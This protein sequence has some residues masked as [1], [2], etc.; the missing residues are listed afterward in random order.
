MPEMQEPVLEQAQKRKIYNAEWR[1][2]HLKK[3]AEYRKRWEI[4]N[5][6]K[7]HAAKRRY[8]ARYPEKRK[9]AKEKYT[10]THSPK[11]IS[12]Y[13][14]E[15][16]QKNIDKLRIKGREYYTKHCEQVKLYARRKRM[17]LKLEV[18]NAYGG[19]I[20]QCCQ[21]TEVQFLSIDHING[22]GVQHRKIQRAG[23]FYPWLKKNG[24]PSGFQVLCMNCNW[25]RRLSGTCPHQ[26]KKLNAEIDS[27]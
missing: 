7:V 24:Y 22:G 8:F 6:D 2:K 15:H 10:A 19:P 17:E 20:C 18:L 12:E 14:A 4:K 23:L 5:P 26:I 11:E 16:Y 9:I 13:N 3:M 1:L 27:K 21:E 25:G